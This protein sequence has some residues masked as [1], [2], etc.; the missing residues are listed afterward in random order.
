MEQMV[1]QVNVVV[2]DEEPLG[3][4]HD[5]GASDTAAW[6]KRLTA[7]DAMN[8]CES[9]KNRKMS[10]CKTSQVLRAEKLFHYACYKAYIRATATTDFSR[11]E[12][13]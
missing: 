13:L 8:Q 3:S 12:F 1:R 7:Y 4:E 10:V 5:N 6:L 9:L 2:R 11:E